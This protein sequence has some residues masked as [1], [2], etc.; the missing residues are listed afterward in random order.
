[1]RKGHIFSVC[2]IFIFT[3]FFGTY[4]SDNEYFNKGEN[5]YQKKEF[6][7]AAVHFEEAKKID[8]GESLIYFYLGNAYYQLNDL[9]NAILNYTAGLNFTD[10]KAP[11]FYNLGNCYFI[12]GN[13]N[14]SSEMYSKAVSS[15][16]TL[17]DS[18]LNT[19]TAHFK[20]GNYAET[21]VQ[22]ETYLE[23]YPE[24]PQYEK[25]EKAIAYLREEM[26]KTT[27]AKDK[28]GSSESGQTSVENDQASSD[29][30]IDLLSDVMNDLEKLINQ[31]ENVMEISEKP[32]DDLSSEDIER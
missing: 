21:I 4:A 5:L 13:Y 30:D 28:S 14:F 31:T 24:T 23:K 10:K 22:W 20:T 27:P 16:P 19:G 25:I 7:L 6:A 29:P 17:Y 8:P 26:N 15:D 18:Y 12:K 3:I 32:I 1:M 2:F 9:D 11:F